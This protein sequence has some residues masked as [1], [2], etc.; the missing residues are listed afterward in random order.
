L[1]KGHSLSLCGGNIDENGILILKPDQ[2]PDEMFK[3]KLSL[4]QSMRGKDSGSEIIQKDTDSKGDPISNFSMNANSLK[5]Q[6]L[7]SQKRT[8]HSRLTKAQNASGTASLSNLKEEHGMVS[9]R[10]Q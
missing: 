10:Q 5:K 8:I 6:Q 7:S 9:T 3:N 1:K 2:Q 4:A